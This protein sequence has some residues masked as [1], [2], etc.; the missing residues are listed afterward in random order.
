[1]LK[2]TID[3][4]KWGMVIDLKKC[5]GCSSCVVACVSGNV[6]PPEVVYRSVIEEKMGSFLVKEKRPT[7][8]VLKMHF[9]LFSCFASCFRN[10]ISDKNE[11]AIAE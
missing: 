10:E 8:S 3:Q 5:V 6:L 4:I 7:R 2:K 9:L 1:M 11:N